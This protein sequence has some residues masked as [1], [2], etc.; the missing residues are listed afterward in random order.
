VVAGAAFAVAAVS[1]GGF[2]DNN[3]TGA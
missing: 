3:P 1:A 2:A